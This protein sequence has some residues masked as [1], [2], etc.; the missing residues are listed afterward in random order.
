MPTSLKWKE[1]V[2]FAWCEE[3]VRVNVPW[4]PVVLHAVLAEHIPRVDKHES[5]K[6]LCFLNRKD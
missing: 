2:R 1:E 5:A 3:R 6:L 4:H